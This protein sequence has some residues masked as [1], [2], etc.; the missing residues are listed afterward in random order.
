MIKV[1]LEVEGKKLMVF[2]GDLILLSGVDKE[3]T[4]ALIAGNASL[5]RVALIHG[6][7]NE[8]LRESGTKL[9]EE[10]I[11]EE[12]FKEIRRS[13]MGRDMLD[14]VGYALF[15]RGKRQ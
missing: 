13:V 9:I 7:A 8:T 11:G 14:A 10:Q 6:A 5:E 3:K 2:E 15:G 1:T 12:G 4:F